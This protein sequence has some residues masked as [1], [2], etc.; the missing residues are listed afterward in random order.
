ML[1]EYF[2]NVCE[3]DLVFNFYKVR[4][5]N[6]EMNFK[7][8]NSVLRGKTE[9]RGRNPGEV[10]KYH[11]NLFSFVAMG[12]CYG[13]EDGMHNY[14]NQSTRLIHINLVGVV[15]PSARNVKQLR[16]L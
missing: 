13:N 7:T 6:V 8:T 1:N 5:K 2:H 16:L 15:F 10:K 11:F 12:G 9:R 3:L 4:V 14:N